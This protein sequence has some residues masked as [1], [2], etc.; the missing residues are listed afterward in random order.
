VRLEHGVWYFDFRQVSA[1]KTV[2]ELLSRRGV[3]AASLRRQLLRLKEWLPDAEQPLQQLSVIEVNGSLLVRLARGELVSDDGQ[4]QL[5]F[6][7]AEAP[8]PMRLVPTP[9]TAEDWHRQGVE[10]AQKGDLTEALESY[11]QALLVGGP[12]HKSRSTSHP[13]S[14]SSTAAKKRLDQ[15]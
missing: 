12:T 1:A 14:S 13:P 6:G 15:A 5:G 10:Q 7:G 3:T 2:C 4:L 8:Q 11:R 9:M